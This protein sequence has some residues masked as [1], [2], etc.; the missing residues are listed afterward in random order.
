MDENSKIMKY[1]GKIK[2]GEKAAFT[3]GE[4]F[5]GG[6]VA[7]LDT[8]FFTFLTLIIKIDAGIAGTIIMLAKIWDAISDPL[9]G[10]ISDNT[11]TKLGRR[12]P[13][14]L[15]S[16][17]LI[18][19]ALI[20]LFMPVMNWAYTTKIVY[21]VLT[22]ILYSTVSTVFNVPYLSL[23]AEICENVKERSNMNMVRLILAALAGAIC[24]V[25]IDYLIGLHRAETINSTQ[26]S[27]IV[28]LGFGIFFAVPVLCTGL[29]TKERTP[30]PKNKTKFSFK[31]FTNTFKLKSFRRLLGMYVFSFVCNAII[32]NILIIFVYNVSGGAAIKILGLGLSTAVFM[33]MLISAG[34]MMPI[35]MLM[36]NL[37]IPKPVIFMLGIPLFIIGAVSLAFFPS[38]ADYKLM[39]VCAAVAG[40]GYGMVQTIP[41]LLFPDIVDVAEL[42]SGDRNPGA[43]NG[44]MTFFKKFASGLAVFMIGIVL[45][46]TGFDSDLGTAA[47]QPPKALTGMRCVLGVSVGVFMV[48]AFVFGYLIKITTKKSER[49]RFF[50][51]KQRAETLNCMTDEEQQELETLKKELF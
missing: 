22:Y 12:R 1:S 35:V 25:V 3:V 39:L 16:S 23:S 34:I 27:F 37:K 14:I 6:G 17:G 13:Y 9:M 33:A 43:Y 24:F 44:T 30:L 21:V 19:V 10:T 51:D 8:F 41:W 2:L 26:I 18:I 29:F 4:L 7:L 46:G 45:Q 20:L 31:N 38:G 28:S 49:I 15:A 11:R 36:L 5:G 32:L 48:L 47:L 50:I 42:K 40:I